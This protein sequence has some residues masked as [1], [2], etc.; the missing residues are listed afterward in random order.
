MLS[1]YIKINTICHYY[2]TKYEYIKERQL[3]YFIFL[4]PSFVQ[5]SEHIYVVFTVYM[6]L[7]SMQIL[8]QETPN[9]PPQNPTRL[10]INNEFWGIPCSVVTILGLPELLLITF[11]LSRVEKRYMTQ[12]QW[13]SRIGWA[14]GLK[15][16]VLGLTGCAPQFE[17]CYLLF[18]KNF[19][20]QRFTPSWV[21]PTRTMIN[22]WLKVWR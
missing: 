18:E 15:V 11:S 21:H 17:S 2:H 14:L 22:L 10:A 4:S 20:G 19:L 5:R 3:G 6:M 16:L 9:R 7:P 8:K 1:C 13:V 12:T